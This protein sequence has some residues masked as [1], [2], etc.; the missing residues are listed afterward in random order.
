MRDIKALKANVCL[1]ILLDDKG[2]VKV[3]LGTT[4]YNQKIA[5]LLKGQAYR[6]FKK[7]PTE[8][9]ENKAFLLLKKSS[10]SEVRQ[11]LWPQSL[12]PP[13]IYGLPNIH[14]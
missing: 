5:A 12:R 3:V 6:K 7:N 4:N 1:I 9:V 8:S 10:I 13:R 2:N 14:K 11:Q